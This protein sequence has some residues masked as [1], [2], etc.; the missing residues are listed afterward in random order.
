MSI[1]AEELT[2]LHIVEG[3][4]PD[5]YEQWFAA[6]R[7]LFR[8]YAG[9]EEGFDIW[10][11]WSRTSKSRDGGEC[12]RQ[13][14]AFSND[15]A[16]APKSD[17]QLRRAIIED[18]AAYLTTTEEIEVFLSE[19]APELI[20]CR[21][22]RHA[23]VIRDALVRIG[24]THIRVMGKPSSAALTGF[25]CARI[26]VAGGVDLAQDVEG[27][28]RLED[29]LRARMATCRDSE[30]IVRQHGELLHPIFDTVAVHEAPFPALC[31]DE[32]CPHHGA[33]HVCL[34]PLTAPNFTV[35]VS[36][37]TNPKD[38]VGVR[39]W[40]QSATVPRLVLHE[41]GVAML[42]GALKYGRHNYRVA[43]VRASVY[44]DAAQGHIDQWWEGEDIDADS[45]LSHIT[46]AIAS[47]VVLRDAMINDMLTDD[48]PPKSNIASVRQDLQG[49]VDYLLDRYP[50]PVPAYTQIGEETKALLV[51]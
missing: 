26:T 24:A 29:L 21:D 4:D 17:E 1:T 43:G 13:W 51:E 39:K 6:G 50:A 44:A 7:D 33:P 10:V 42:E 32:G 14:T 36:K 30:F 9:S 15:A 38:A 41:V 46:K 34:P 8:D 3:R 47:L 40:R 2:H 5:R 25:A 45:R 18:A 35:P 27:E 11:K 22:D 31:E 19:P 28:G 48:R 37:D 23:K 20:V 49:V 16:S 12:R